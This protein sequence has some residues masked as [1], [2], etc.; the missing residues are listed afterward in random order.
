MTELAPKSAADVAASLR[1]LHAASRKVRIT[2]L[3]TRARFVAPLPE[4][5]ARLSLRSLA[6]IERL[7]A[8]DLTCSVQPGVTCRELFDAL[9]RA[10][11]ELDCIDEADA[12]TIGGLYACDPLPCASPHAASP[13]STLLGIDGVL[14]NGAE[15]RSGA[16]VVKSVAGFDVHRLLVGSRGT[17]FAATLLHLKLRPAPRAKAVFASERTTLAAAVETMH[18]LRCHPSSP[19]R[20]SL[21]RDGDAATVLGI[22]TGRPRPVQ[23]LLTQFSLRESS[24]APAP[25]LP[26]PTH[27][28]EL[29]VG[30]VRPSR[31]LA[32]CAALPPNAPFLVHGGGHF[33]VELDPAHADVLFAEM[34]R[35]GGHAAVAIGAQDRVGTGT[36]LDA[37]AERLQRELRSALDPGALLA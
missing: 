20:L 24:A 6:S 32:L 37:G 34:M 27:G 30:V 25:H 28:R 23:A 36:R 18:A 31:I 16:R 29:V 17:L 15:F 7:E 35:I 12:G 22:A 4:G 1:E 10:H 2:G 11:L 19:K 3:G 9:Q 14:A 5:T 13:R 21:V 33:E 26:P 8:D